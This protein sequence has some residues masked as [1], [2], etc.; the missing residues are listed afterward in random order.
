MSKELEALKEL[1]YKRFYSNGVGV[2]LIDSYPEL[3]NIIEQSLK[4]QEEYNNARKTLEKD[5]TKLDKLEQRI[6]QLSNMT[7][8]R[9]NDKQKILVRIY[10]DYKQSIKNDIS[11]LV[12]IDDIEQLYIYL[13]GEIKWLTKN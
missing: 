4:K 3:F 2:D 10:L 13:E 1:K 7:A 8:R 9:L 12:G 6:I 11:T 5:L